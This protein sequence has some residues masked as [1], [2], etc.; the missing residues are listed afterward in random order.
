MKTSQKHLKKWAILLV[1]PLLFASFSVGPQKPK[2]SFDQDRLNM[3]SNFEYGTTVPR[4]YLMSRKKI[5]ASL[6]EEFAFDGIKFTVVSYK[7]I[8]VPKNG[9]AVMIKA[10]SERIT[11]SMKSKIKSSK[12]GDMVLVENIRAEGPNGIVNLA[13]LVFRIM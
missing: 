5:R 3:P 2:K 7:F 9:N 11:Q 12:K 10:N 13:P 4:E 6:G 1:T 8:F